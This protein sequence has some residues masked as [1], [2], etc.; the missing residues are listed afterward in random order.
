MY[1]LEFSKN[2]IL[3]QTVALEYI[4]LMLFNPNAAKKLKSKIDDKIDKI[5]VFPEGFPVFDTKRK[6][7]YTYRK[8]TGWKKIQNSWYYFNAD[9]SLLVNGTTPDGYPVGADGKMM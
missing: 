5:I 3:D 2:I 4:A 1:K 6:T 9:G 7:E 8:V